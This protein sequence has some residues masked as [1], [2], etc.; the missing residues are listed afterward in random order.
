MPL[1]KGITNIQIVDG[2]GSLIRDHINGP[3]VSLILAVA[4][5]DRRLCDYPLKDSMEG[6]RRYYEPYIPENTIVP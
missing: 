3:L 2:H 5:K 1:D 4:H 6:N